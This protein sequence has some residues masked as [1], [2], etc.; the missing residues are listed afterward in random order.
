MGGVAVEG[1]LGWLRRGEV[2]GFL[3]IP[4]MGRKRSSLERVGG[5]RGQGMLS[6]LEVSKRG[7]VEESG[8]L[9]GRMGVLVW[10]VRDCYL[11]CQ[12]RLS[13]HPSGGLS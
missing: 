4:E 13:Q 2:G 6:C 9:I 5:R 1:G 7:V 12:R 3:C 10:C 8:E 11:M